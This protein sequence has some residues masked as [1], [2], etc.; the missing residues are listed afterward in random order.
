MD[1]LDLRWLLNEVHGPGFHRVHSR[2]N[3]P[4]SRDHDHGRVRSDDPRAPQHFQS[5]GAGHHEI[6]ERCIEYAHLDLTDG[7]GPVRGGFDLVAVLPRSSA[8]SDRIVGSS[9]AIRIFVGYP[10]E[11]GGP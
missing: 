1:C 8:S 2:I 7:L 4:L 11:A 3:G 5:G 6:Q 10:S 9:S